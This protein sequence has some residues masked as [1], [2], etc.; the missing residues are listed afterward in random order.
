MLDMKNQEKQS[1]IEGDRGERGFSFF[2]SFGWNKRGKKPPVRDKKKEGWKDILVVCGLAVGFSLLI[3]IFF[4]EMFWIP[5]GSMI[6]TLLE[7]DLLVVSKVSYGYS[8]YSFPFGGLPVGGR[9]FGEEPERGDVL[10]FRGTKRK[11]IDYVKRL[12]GLPGDTV[13]VKRG[14]LFINGEPVR[15][16]RLSDYTISS[17]GV[18]GRDVIRYGERLPNGVEHPIL[19]IDDDFGYADDTPL[20]KVPDGHYFVMGDNRDNSVDSRF[21]RDIG[22]VPFDNL[23]GRAQMILLSFNGSYDWWKIWRWPYLVRY[24]RL[25]L[26]VK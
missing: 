5:S 7:G 17:G 22:F 18:K 11:N 3:R 25:G 2:T 24:E 8:R 20:Y 9:L 16:M 19:E 13:Q 15:R 14:I 26:E 23:V 1:S 12:V 6:P 4:F 10:V 21:I